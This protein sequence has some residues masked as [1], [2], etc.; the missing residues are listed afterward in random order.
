MG[1]NRFCT[2]QINKTI[3]N[4]C[5]YVWECLFFNSNI[6][7]YKIIRFHFVP[8][9]PLCFSLPT[10]DPIETSNLYVWFFSEILY[11]QNGVHR[12]NGYA[13]VYCSFR[14]LSIQ[15]FAVRFGINLFKCSITVSPFP[16]T[17]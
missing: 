1:R 11:R 17:H 6:K 16:P 4:A 8:L 2:Q 14:L 5:V 15:L 12:N 13:S 3:V 9:N 10:P 7:C